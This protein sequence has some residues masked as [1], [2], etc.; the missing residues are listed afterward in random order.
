MRDRVSMN[1][2]VVFARISLLLS[3]LYVVVEATASMAADSAEPS[4]GR[5]IFVKYCSGC[6][7]AQGQGDGYPLLGR[8]PAN[9]ASPAT[10]E[11]TDEDLLRTIHEGKPNM[12]PW[13]YRLSPQDSHDVLAYIRSLSTQLNK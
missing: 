8:E 10:K 5:K 6:H 1:L 12:P 11:Q 9:L 4:R 2:L 3:F 7:G 13:K